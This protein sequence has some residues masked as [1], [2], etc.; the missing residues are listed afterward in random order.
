MAPDKAA[1]AQRIASG[2]IVL[3][4][5][6][7]IVTMFLTY[8][9]LSQRARIDDVA[10]LRAEVDKLKIALVI[11]QDQNLRLMRKALDLE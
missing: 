9:Q 10:A 2:S 11:C 6:F 5:T 3:S 1:R 7:G 4:A 8:T